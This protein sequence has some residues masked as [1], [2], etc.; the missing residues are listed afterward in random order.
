MSVSLKQ[1]IEDN[2]VMLIAGAF[3]AGVSMGWL[4]SEKVQVDP[5]QLEN[6][7][8]LV[9]L[10]RLERYDIP[11][12]LKGSPLVLEPQQQCEIVRLYEELAVAVEK[13]DQKAIFDLYTDNYSSEISKDAVLRA[14]RNLLGNK[15]FFYISLIRHNDDGTVAVNVKAFLP[16]GKY[17]DSKDILVFGD[18]GW[19][20]VR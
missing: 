5:C 1:R 19:R 3:A 2:A 8:L 15:L 16:S 18:S 4:V 9:R 6:K 17:I 12:L 10:E 13:A 7:H 14:Y 20:F 11:Q